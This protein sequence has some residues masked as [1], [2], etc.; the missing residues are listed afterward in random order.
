M[1]T[2]ARWR[3]DEPTLPVREAVAAAL[4]HGSY[5]LLVAGFFVCGFHLAFIT[6]HLPAHISAAAG[7]RP[8]IARRQTRHSGLGAGGHRVDE[9]GGLLHRRGAR[10]GARTLI[11][12]DRDGRRGNDSWKKPHNPPPESY[13][14]RIWPLNRTALLIVRSQDFDLTS[15]AEAL[16][17]NMVILIR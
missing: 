16:I 5:L 14:R 10:R 6:T 13:L 11:R 12:K 17:L 9:R 7:A 8:R 1:T 3:P 2:F 4:G 15:V